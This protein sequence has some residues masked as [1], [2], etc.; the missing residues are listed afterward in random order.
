MAKTRIDARRIKRMRAPPRI[1]SIAGDIGEDT[2]MEND[3]DLI[4]TKEDIPIEP[5]HPHVVSSVTMRPEYSAPNS[6]RTSVLMYPDES[7]IRRVSPPIVK[8]NEF[9]NNC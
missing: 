1:I 5:I 9:W 8:N 3:S 4:I 2:P 6:I 7:S